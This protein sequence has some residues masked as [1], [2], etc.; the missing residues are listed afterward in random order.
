MKLG[1]NELSLP[2]K[3]WRTGKVMHSRRRVAKL[4]A[5]LHAKRM[6]RV[7]LTDKAYRV[8]V[9]R[10]PWCGTYHVGRQRLYLAS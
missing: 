10:C 4:H 6:R 8:N 5:K 9:Y 1:R 7:L 3:C 2:A